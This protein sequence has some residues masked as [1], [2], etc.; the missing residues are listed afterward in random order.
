MKMRIGIVGLGYIGSVTG[1]VLASKGHDVVGVDIDKER[2]E[3]F[4][5][6][7]MPLY[8]PG[9]KQT[10]E[11]CREKIE[12]TS[13]YGSLRGAEAIFVCVATPSKNG[14]IDLTYVK[15]ACKSIQA[16]SPE[17]TI[18]IKS[19]VVPGTAKEVME[20]TGMKVVSNPEFTREGTA[21]NDT[22]KPDRVVVGSRS[23]EGYELLRRIW[24]FVESPFV[25]TTNENAELIKYAS[26]SFL[27]T[28][29]SFINEYAN[30]CEKIEN[31]D[32]TSV[33]LGMGLDRR[34]GKDFLRAGLG[35]GGSCFPKDTEAIAAFAREKGEK[36]SIVEAAMSVNTTRER[37]I[38]QLCELSSGS[39]L[40]GMKV[41]LLGL[42]FKDD[43]DDLRESKSLKL[44]NAMKRDG[45]EVK[46]FDPIIKKD[47]IPEACDSISQCLEGSDLAILATEWPQFSDLLTGFKGTLIDARRIVGPEKVKKYV[48]V[49]R[50]YAEN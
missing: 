5:S 24:N 31:A 10:L 29:I 36:L 32:V 30:L 11:S 49:G 25:E 19:T 8:E 17:S 38:I 48:G 6:G 4:K 46:T 41:C 28:K 20:E 1:A 37:R 33:A 26:N 42:S 2:V 18:V 47:K 50:Y 44:L 34:I 43:T 23:Q 40:T 27:A 45:A 14:K 39:K 35:F 21:I 22:I 13:D 7:N 9:L 12:F 3:S 15:E 16:N